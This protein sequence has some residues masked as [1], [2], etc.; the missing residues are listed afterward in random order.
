MSR[1]VFPLSAMLVAGIAAAQ[2]AQITTL[3]PSDDLRARADTL[4]VGPSLTKGIQV[5]YGGKVRVTFEMANT[6]EAEGPATCT[7]SNTHTPFQNET[8]TFETKTIDAPVEARGIVE[9]FCT[10]NFATPDGL[11]DLKLRRFRVYYDI[12]NR[13]DNPVVVQN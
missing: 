6:A 9:V 12:E 8:T 5:P 13:S 2:A 11:Q 10:G 7:V 3:V 4:R 1:M